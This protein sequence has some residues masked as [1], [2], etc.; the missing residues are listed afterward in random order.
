MT[1]VDHEKDVALSISVVLIHGQPG[2]AEDF[3]EIQERFPLSVKAIAFDRPGWGS[4][5]LKAGSLEE[6]AKA[7]LQFVDTLETTNLILVGYSY[8]AAVA[9]RA[10]C[11]FEGSFSGLVLVAPVGGVG[12]ISTL[13]R[14]LSWAAKAFRKASMLRLWSEAFQERFRSFLSF[15]FEQ[16]IL[17]KDLSDLWHRIDRIEIP[18][19]LIAG[20]D[21]FLNPLS[22]TLA[23]QRKL[24]EANMHLVNGAGH[25]LLDQAPEMIVA[26]VLDM[27]NRVSRSDY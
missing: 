13:D 22:G 12:S 7:L 25:M 27:V 8:G 1:W 15:Q 2:S 9:L 23:L 11:D 18:I 26:S 4:S 14:A 24:R 6:N 21:D 10:A 16:T 19:E 20:E 3:L 5:P 17:E